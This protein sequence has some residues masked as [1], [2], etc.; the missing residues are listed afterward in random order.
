MY[1]VVV[2]FIHEQ[3]YAFT[4]RIELHVGAVLVMKLPECIST[5]L[6]G[7]QSGNRCPTVARVPT[8]LLC[9]DQHT[10]HDFTHYG[11]LRAAQRALLDGH[12]S[13]GY[14]ATGAE[15]AAN[16]TARDSTPH[17]CYASDSNAWPGSGQKGTGS[18]PKTCQD[19]SILASLREVWCGRCDLN[20]HDLLG[21]ADFRTISAF[22]ASPVTRSWSGLSLHHRS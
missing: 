11:T 8:C 16:S 6:H 18:G 15:G 2:P 17:S 1:T 20:P 19:G 9:V 10:I 7:S 3:L 21:S 14:F 4:I 5:E 13:G 12:T 22:A